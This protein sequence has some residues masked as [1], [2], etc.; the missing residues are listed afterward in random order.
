MSAAVGNGKADGEMFSTADMNAHVGGKSCALQA[1]SG[2]WYGTGTIC[3]K[4]SLNGEYGTNTKEKGINW[5]T[6]RGMSYSLKSSVLKLRKPSL[7]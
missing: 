3:S 5:D 4:S 7:H 1:R 6:F 2:W